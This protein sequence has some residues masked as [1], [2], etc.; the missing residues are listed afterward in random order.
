MMERETTHAERV[1]MIE[2]RLAGESMQTIA[3][4]LGRN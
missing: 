4:A 2:R 1:M 3:T